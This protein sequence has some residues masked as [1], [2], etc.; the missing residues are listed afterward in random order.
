[1]KLATEALVRLKEAR[2]GLTI[3]GTAL[4]AVVAT[5]AVDNGALNHPLVSRSTLAVL[6]ETRHMTKQAQVDLGS[7]T[8]RLSRLA[9][10]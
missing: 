7:V 8:S 9:T 5:N 2:A 10:R 1:M 4:T 6:A 3:V